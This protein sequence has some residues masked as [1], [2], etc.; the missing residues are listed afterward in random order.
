MAEFCGKCGAVLEL[1]AK[2]C[3]KCGASIV[4]PLKKGIAV[5]N[6]TDGERSYNKL[7]IIAIVVAIIVFFAMGA[8]GYYVY[9]QN[10]KTITTEK[11]ASS[12]SQKE[13][14][15]KNSD[16]KGIINTA[17]PDVYDRN[18]KAEDEKKSKVSYYAKSA[19]TSLSYNEKTLKQVADY[20]NSGKYDKDFLLNRVKGCQNEMKSQ[21]LILKESKNR[22]SE[23]DGLIDNLYDLQQKRLECMRKGIMGDKSQFAVGGQYYEEYQT[24]LKQLESNQ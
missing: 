8:G 6:D 2:F 4:E 21:I 14:D 12:N 1:N 19:I 22:I 15:K 3:K 20:I 23:I 5:N 9:T 13:Q 17:S 24:K 16:V 10:Q 11:N 7:T 18:A